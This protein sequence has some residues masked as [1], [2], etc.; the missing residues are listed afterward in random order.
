MAF[1]RYLLM[2]VPLAC[3]ACAPFPHFVTVTPDINGTLTSDGQPVAGQEIRLARGPDDSPCSITLDSVRTGPDGGF[4]LERKTQFQLLYAP[5]VAPLSVSP[6]N[7]CSTTP[8]KPLLL[9]R[10]LVPLYNAQP[11]KLACTLKELQPPRQ[12]PLQA[13]PPCKTSPVRLG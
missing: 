8:D 2:L 12:L 6:F 4:K 5:L 9:Y 3:A 1:S 10:G 11:L 7:I 13:E